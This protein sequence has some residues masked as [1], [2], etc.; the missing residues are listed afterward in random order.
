MRLGQVRGGEIQPGSPLLVETMWQ[1][2]TTPI[3]NYSVSA[4]LL[5]ETGRRVAQADGRPFDGAFDTSNWAPTDSYPDATSLQIPGGLAPGEYHLAISVY[6]GRL[7][8]G[9]QT[10]MALPYLPGSS[11]GF[12]G[13]AVTNAGWTIDRVRLGTGAS[14]ALVVVVTGVVNSSPDRAYTWFAHVL[15]RQ[16]RLLAQ[17]DHPPVSGTMSWRA[18]DPIQEVF[19]MP[20]PGASQ[21]E[22]GAYDARGTRV[23]FQVDGTMSDHLLI[24]PHE[25]I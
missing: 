19:Q 25:H 9:Q 24:D 13:K 10:V 14:G 2:S 12:Q 20:D 4:Q 23:Q 15:D 3:K 6:D 18:G 22:I 16:G 7:S 5:D 1:V 11:T 17:D 21:V 8:L